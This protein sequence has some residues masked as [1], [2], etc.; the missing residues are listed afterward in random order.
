MM[1]KLGG[2]IPGDGEEFTV[3]AHA[4]DMVLVPRAELDALRAEIRRL[5]RM[6]PGTM[7]RWSAFSQTPGKSYLHS[8]GTGRGLGN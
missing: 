8:R 6:R 5:R 2:E 4:E 3:T 1:S 7:K